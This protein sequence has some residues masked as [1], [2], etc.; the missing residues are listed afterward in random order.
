MD[1]TTPSNI[2]DAASKIKPKNSLDVNNISTKMV[3]YTINDIATPM[4]HIINL[5]F[6][7]GI[8]PD[9]MKIANI[10]PIFKSGDK[11]S[12]NNYRPISILPAFSKIMEKNMYF[13][14]SNFLNSS[15]QY[16]KHQY[17]V[18]K[19][20]S[21][22]HHVLQLINYIAQENDKPSRNFTLATFLDLSKAFD[23]ISHDILLHKLDNIGVRGLSNMWFQSYLSNRRQFMD[24]NDTKSTLETIGTGVPQGSILV[25]CYF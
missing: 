1:P 14:L 16:Y 25:L 12:F 8:I 17:G 23:T 15:K 10:I 24:I 13:K 3:K 11:F 20:H 2:I 21:T 6:S 19:G 5:T 9:G 4:S 18:S 7:T 22:L